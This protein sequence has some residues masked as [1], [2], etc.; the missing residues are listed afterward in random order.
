MT[1][2]PY[3][4]HRTS[5]PILRNTLGVRMDRHAATHRL[6][7]LAQAAGIHMPRMHPPCFATRS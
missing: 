3:V 7:H 1:E 5:G 2:D 6:K 4:A